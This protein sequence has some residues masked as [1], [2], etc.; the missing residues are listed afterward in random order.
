[1]DGS[2]KI[3]YSISTEYAYKRSYVHNLKHIYYNKMLYKCSGFEVLMMVY[4][5]SYFIKCI[6]IKTKLGN[7]IADILS[8]GEHLMVG[9]K[10]RFMINT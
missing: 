6:M 7:S 3:I 8:K 1:M 9:K 2:M 5:Y 4:Q 10:L